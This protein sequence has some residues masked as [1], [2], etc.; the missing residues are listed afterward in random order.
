MNEGARKRRAIVCF[1][2]N[3]RCRSGKR[4]DWMGGF[5][6]SSLAVWKHDACL[7]V[8]VEESTTRRLSDE[9]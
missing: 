2:L 4:W 9:T 3:W 7:L 1:L 5:P 6:R 8:G